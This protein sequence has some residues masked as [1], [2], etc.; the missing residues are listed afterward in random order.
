MINENQ[1]NEIVFNKY[2]LKKNNV[3]FWGSPLKKFI[4]K[5]YSKLDIPEESLCIS[6]FY[7]NK[8][9]YLNKKNLKLIDD[10]F[11][12]IKVY[13]FSSIVISLKQLLDFKFN[14]NDM[15]NLLDI[16]YNHYIITELKILTFLNW[17]TFL[18]NEE[19]FEFK[20]LL[21]RYMD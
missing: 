12:N 5:I 8:F 13:I 3:T 11:N 14:I 20:K 19:Y 17:D 10:F 2:S 21:V 6:L 9:Y 1:F 16:N 18:N 7:L 4:K 15:T